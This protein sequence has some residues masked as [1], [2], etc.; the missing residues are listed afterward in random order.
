ML[1]SLWTL[2]L[3][4]ASTA[5]AHATMHNVFVNG[6]DQ[7][8]GEG[9]YIRSPSSNDPVRDLKSR[10]LACNTK[11]GDPVPE[12]VKVSAGDELSFRWYHYNPNDP[13]DILDSSHKGAILTYIAPYTEGNGAGPI[14]SKIAQEDFENGQW[15]TIKMIENGGKV[16]F[17]LPKSLA[18]GQYLIRQELLALHMADTRGDEDPNRGAESY[19]SC[20]QVE[21]EE[22]P[23][24]AI[25]DQDFDFNKGYKY[26]DPGIFFNIHVPFESYTPPGPPIWDSN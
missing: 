24:E 5:S 12:F 18:P 4:L 2:A 23:G 19:P 16:D 7:G 21:V 25:P 9:K 22:G 17:S 10:D 1:L 8:N 6:K 14:W 13:G 26:D 15:A 3:G 20:V 11:G